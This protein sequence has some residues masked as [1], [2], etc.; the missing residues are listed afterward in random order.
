MTSPHGFFRFRVGLWFVRLK[1]FLVRVFRLLCVNRISS[2]RNIIS[3]MS[4]Q[5][6]VAE[7]TAAVRRRRRRTRTGRRRRRR[8]GTESVSQ[9]PINSLSPFLPSSLAAFAGFGFVSGRVFA[10]DARR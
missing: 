7:A 6:A 9:F 10:H 5:R 2:H 3:W 1:F 4:S 8:H